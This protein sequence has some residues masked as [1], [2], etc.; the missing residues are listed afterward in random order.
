MRCQTD[1]FAEKL[2]VLSI[3]KRL[4]VEKKLNSEI[5]NY[6]RYIERNN[7]LIDFNNKRQ[8]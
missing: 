7:T 1:S 6:D 3:Y 2:S 5:Q 4:D 8:G